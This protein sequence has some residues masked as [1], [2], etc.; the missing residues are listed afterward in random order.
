MPDVDAEYLIDY[1]FEIGP[2]MAG[3]MGEAPLSHG[4]LAAWQ[5]NVGIDLQP[6]EVRFLRNLSIEYLSQAQKSDKP[7]CPPP[8]GTAERRALVGKKLDELFG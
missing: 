4:E 7:D 1:L 6:W 8:Y 5:A 3:G 2:T